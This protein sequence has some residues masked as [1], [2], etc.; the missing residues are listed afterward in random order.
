MSDLSGLSKNKKKY[1]LA[2]QSKK[3]R[4]KY[5]KFV[6]EGDKIAREFL[7]QNLFLPE[8]IFATS[9][10]I[11]TNKKSLKV[12]LNKVITLSESELK[13]VSSLSTPNQV[14]VVADIHSWSLEEEVSKG[15][16]LYLDGIRDPGNMGTI[17]RIA[18]WFGISTVYCSSDCVDLYLSKVVQAAMGAILRVPTQVCSLEDLTQ[19]NP[20]WPVYGTVLDGSSIYEHRLPEAGLIVIG[21]EGRGIKPDN[22]KFLHHKISLPANRQ[23][24]TESLNAAV[25]TG[26]FCALFRQPKVK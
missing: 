18:D 1:L 14:L 12:H 16:A 24:G 20:E 10:W 7:H 17:L 9:S 25:A 23:S 22:L 3:Q 26:I 6:V 4:Q 8:L 5:N 13:Q 2:L 15:L 21:N 11:E 19:A